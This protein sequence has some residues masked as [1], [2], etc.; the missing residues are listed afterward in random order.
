MEKRMGKRMIKKMVC[1]LTALAMAVISPAPA[2]RAD[3]TPFYYIDND[4]VNSDYTYSTRFY[5]IKQAYESDDGSVRIRIFRFAADISDAQYVWLGEPVVETCSP[6]KNLVDLSSVYSVL[7]ISITTR[8]GHGITYSFSS[9]GDLKTCD[10][11]N[12]EFGNEVIEIAIRQKPGPY[13]PYCKRHVGDQM[14]LNGVYVGVPVITF[15]SQPSP[16]TIRQGEDAAFELQADY[17]KSYL[18]DLP[19]VTT[20]GKIAQPYKWCVKENGNWREL[21]DGPGPS[22]EEYSG[23]DTQ[24]LCIRNAQTSMS[25]SEYSCKLRGVYLHEVFSDPAPLTVLDPEPTATP[26]PE[27]TASPTPEPVVTTVPEPTASPT[28]EPVVTTVPEPTASPTPGPVITTVPEPTK[29]PSPTAAPVP[30]SA[31]VITPGG[32]SGGGYRPAASSS[33]Y[34]PAPYR[35]GKKRDDRKDNKHNEKSSTSARTDTRDTYRGDIRTGAA[36]GP[37]IPSDSLIAA[38]DP[39]ESPPG[40]S[41]K[42]EQ[43]KKSTPGK[44]GSSSSGG[45]GGTGG[46][47]GSSSSSTSKTSGT[48]LPGSSTVMKNGVLY[49]VGDEDTGVG[50]AGELEGSTAVE[51]EEVESEE[52]YGAADLGVD[53]EAYEQSAAKGFFQTMPGYIVIIGSAFLILLL[54]LFFLFF[55][56]LVFGEVEEH[57]EVFE[58]CGIRLMRRREGNWCV[59]LGSAFDEN[60]VLKL[61]I[62]IL[63]ARIFDDWDITGEVSGMYEGEIVSQAKQNMMFYR[64]NVRR[65]I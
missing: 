59:N 65:S 64:K 47:G 15:R 29:A 36:V 35:P 62:G 28:P 21:T 12:Y 45:T 20:G 31:P 44:S 26:T 60:A 48:R 41:G 5:N 61:R 56:V 24:N 46:S 18:K 57:D 17:A 38:K 10:L 27:P 58:L 8:N 40:S 42:S 1:I 37:A 63:F 4:T 19:C 6:C 14:R 34:V 11:S 2:V 3:E 51:E 9:E 55:G 50:T 53:A 25:G 49:I 22:G 16:V 32:G 33:V 30:T 43:K 23:T 39:A 13:C 52:A 54:A 7:R